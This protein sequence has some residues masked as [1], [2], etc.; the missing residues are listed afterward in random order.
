M[1]GRAGPGQTTHRLLL[2]E[3]VIHETEQSLH[4][5]DI[6]KSRSHNLLRRRELRMGWLKTSVLLISLFI[7][8]TQAQPSNTTEPYNVCLSHVEPFVSTWVSF[9]H[10][11]L[12][13]I[14]SHPRRLIS[15]L[16]SIPRRSFAK[17][18]TKANTLALMYPYL[19]TLL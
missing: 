14:L 18:L 4:D 5:F 17:A 19:E 10:Q 3:V 1:T 9:P 11:P 16:D 6:A 12:A 7:L 2:L 15:A 8:K 13:T